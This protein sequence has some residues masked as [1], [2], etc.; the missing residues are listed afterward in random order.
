[1]AVASTTRLSRSFPSN[2][3][4]VPSSRLVLN[5]AALFSSH[6]YLWVLVYAGGQYVV[7]SVTKHFC[8][9][10]RGLCIAGRDSS[11]QQG[12]VLAS[13]YSVDKPCCLIAS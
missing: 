6:T 3:H 12:E 8:S 5:V 4:R 7:T 10:L 11:G 13:F 9:N 2:P 1:M